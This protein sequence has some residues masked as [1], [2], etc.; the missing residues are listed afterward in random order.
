MKTIAQY[1]FAVLWAIAV[2][3]FFPKSRREDILAI[4]RLNNSKRFYLD[5]RVEV[6]EADIF[7]PESWGQWVG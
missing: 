2:L 1:F 6:V 7:D 4:A 5:V 3:L